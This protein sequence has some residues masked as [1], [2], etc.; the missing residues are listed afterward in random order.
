MLTVSCKEKSV[1][2]RYKYYLD[3]IEIIT[4]GSGANRAPQIYMPHVLLSIPLFV[5]LN[6]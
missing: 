3:W 2:G 5:K 1:S 4:I 6:A